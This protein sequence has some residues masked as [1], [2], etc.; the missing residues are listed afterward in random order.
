MFAWQFCSFTGSIS[1]ELAGWMSWEPCLPPDDLLYRIAVRD[2]GASNADRAMAAWRCFDRAMEHFPFSYFTSQF[3]RGPFS[4]GF[5][6]PLVL[7]PLFSVGELPPSFWSSS[8]GVGGPAD[9][10]RPMF[11]ADLLWLHPFGFDAGLKALKKTERSWSRGCRLLDSCA[12]P[13]RVDAYASARLDEHQALARAV[14]CM[15]R[16]AV[17][18]VRFLDVRDRYFRESSDLRLVRR[19]LTEMRG[20]AAAE[21]NNADEGLRCMSRNVRIG[22]DHGNEFGFTEEMVRA[23]I[24]HTRRLIEWSLPYRMFIHSYG[25]GARDEWIGNRTKYR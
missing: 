16:T 7:D 2:F 11:I 9:L 13:G 10:K 24:V 19:R 4:L 20:I 25:L 1:E 15:L 8:A 18:T 22:F 5:A 14:L 12:A 3:R 17:N 21:L 6:H 23:K